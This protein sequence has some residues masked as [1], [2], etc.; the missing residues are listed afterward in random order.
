MR[1]EASGEVGEFIRGFNRF[2]DLAKNRIHDLE[3]Q[4]TEVL[5]SSKVVAY[6]KSRVE[7]VIESLPEATVVLDETGST[8]FANAKLETVLGVPSGLA[9]G[10][11]PVDWCSE[12]AIRGILERCLGHDNPQALSERLSVSG[13]AGERTI[14]LAT[15][16]LEAQGVSSGFVG[17][18]VVMRDVTS[19][20]LMSRAQGEFVTHVAHELKAPLNVMAMYGESLLGEQG[21]AESFRVEASNVIR[22]E[23]ERLATMIGTL[24]S[25]ARIESGAVSVER[26]PIRLEEFLR[27]AVDAAS[28]SARTP[29]L[30]FVLDLP[31]ETAPTYVD[32]ELFR[33]A[34]NNLLTNA[35]KYNRPGGEVTVTVDE[36]PTRVAIRV[37]D[38]GIGI[39]EEDLP[40]VFDKFYRSPDPEAEKRGGHG[41]G[42]PLA[43]EIVELHGGT[44]SVQSAPDEGSE[45][46][47]ELRRR[48][49]ERRDG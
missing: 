4:K 19:D 16:P 15:Y 36:T 1:I 37:R 26:Q 48:S 13:E 3:E 20:A 42:L 38:T 22:D 12:P 5:A 31:P 10:R 8:V 7:S 45:F 35:A 24:L 33:I 28:R 43:R 41:L 47:I 40:H 44:I 46:T 14:D 34:L 30:R 18:L 6:Q 9:L 29:D 23:V 21:E 11:K 32:K 49:R 39:R 2:M 17:T 25:I 27:D